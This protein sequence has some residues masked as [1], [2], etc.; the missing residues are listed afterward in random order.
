MEIGNNKQKLRKSGENV[1]EIVYPSMSTLRV[2]QVVLDLWWLPGINVNILNFS[3]NFIHTLVSAPSIVIASFVTLV[4]DPHKE[5]RGVVEVFNAFTLSFLIVGLWTLKYKGSKFTWTNKQEGEA[6]I[7]E[8]IDR[9]MC[10]SKFKEVFCKAIFFRLEPIG[11]NHCSFALHSEFKDIKTPRQF[12]FEQMW[13]SHDGFPNVVKDSWKHKE[14]PSSD[15]LLLF[16]SNI[17][18]YSS[19]RNMDDAL[20]FV[21]RAISD[22]DDDNSIL[23]QKV[24]MEEVKQIVFE[25]GALKAPGPDGFSSLFYSL[26]GAHQRESV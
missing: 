13:L 1:S 19:E 11:S 8:R 17:N 25:L 20:F 23:M 24:S 15:S 7:K 18:R 22:D 16:L 14:D 3:K 4:Y 2:Y 10:N 5:D 21:N 26:L 9:A 12:K 6:H